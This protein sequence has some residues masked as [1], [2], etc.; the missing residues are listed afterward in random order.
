[1]D[2][3]KLRAACLKRDPVCCH[4]DPATGQQTCDRPSRHADHVVPKSAGGADVLE[5]LQGMCHRHHSQKTAREDGGFGNA[6]KK[7]T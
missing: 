4:R 3:K 6:R 7:R 5:N 2:W 1:M